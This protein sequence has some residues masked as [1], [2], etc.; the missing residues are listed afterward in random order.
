MGAPTPENAALSKEEE[1][2]V[3]VV[4]VTMAAQLVKDAPQKPVYW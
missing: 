1:S 2:V 3:V 4:V